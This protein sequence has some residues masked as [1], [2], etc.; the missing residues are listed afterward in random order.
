MSSSSGIS[1][2]FNKY[3]QSNVQKVKYVLTEV[4][5]ACLKEIGRYARDEAR[6]RVPGKTGNLKKNISYQIRR[7]DKSVRL[8]V[9]RKAFYGLFVEKGHKIVPKGFHIN[10][11]TGKMVKP[12]ALSL[13]NSI[14]GIRKDGTTYTKRRWRNAISMEFGGKTIPA[15]PFLAPA[16]KENVDHIRLIAGKYFKEIEKD[17][18]TIGLLGP[19]DGERDDS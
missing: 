3:Y 19:D 6:E 13:Q 5:K 16:V 15:R 17:N 18:I 12:G 1:K 4:E 14:V 7:K 2:Y 10:Q 11:R 8:G 9:K